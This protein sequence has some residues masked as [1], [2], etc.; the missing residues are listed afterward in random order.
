MWMRCRGARERLEGAARA[1]YAKAILSRTAHILILPPNDA[2]T[3]ARLVAIAEEGG[4]IALGFFRPG[5]QTRAGIE[6]KGDGSPVTEADFAVNAFL[7]RELRVLWPGAAWLSEESVDD[8]RRLAASHVII[9]DP[10]DGTRGF[11]R[12]DPFWAIAIALVEA[13]RPIAAIVHAP[14]LE[15]TYTAVKGLGATLNGRRLQLQPEVDLRDDMRVSCPGVLVKAL[16][17][18]GL[19]FAFQPKIASLALRVVKVASG[20]Y[21]AGLT[22]SDSHDWDIA[23]SDLVLEEAGGLLAGL[24]GSPVSYNRANPSHGVLTATVRPL[25]PSFRKAVGMTPFGREDA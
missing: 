5:L 25:Q 8:E 24:D 4:R 18:A 2:E 19:T 7:E 1:R 21:D 16:Q 11:A 12:G 20:V 6:W 15:E 9:V 14:A 3:L 10:I 17:V 22:T 13:G 23:A